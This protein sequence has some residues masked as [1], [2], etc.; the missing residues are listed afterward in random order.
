MIDPTGD[1]PDPKLQYEFTCSIDNLDDLARS[2]LEQANCRTEDA[3][4]E[5]TLT[6]LKD[7]GS[8]EF[9][10]RGARWIGRELSRVNVLTGRLLRATSIRI[11]PSPGPTTIRAGAAWD[12]QPQLPPSHCGWSDEGAQFRLNAW[13]LSLIH[14]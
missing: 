6:L 12:H 4:V 5:F 7:E 11:E 1:V 2:L 13:D 8:D 10:E 14:I 9:R 3:S